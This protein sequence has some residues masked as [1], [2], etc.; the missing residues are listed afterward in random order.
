[1]T[2]EEILR[3]APEGCTHYLGDSCYIDEHY[4]DK[5]PRYDSPFET[6]EKIL[7]M[8]SLADIARIVELEKQNKWISVD[9]RLPEITLLDIRS[10]SVLVLRDCGNGTP[11]SSCVTF[12]W[13]ESQIMSQFHN[14]MYEKAERWDGQE[15]KGYRVT[16]WM[17]LP[18]F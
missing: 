17:P 5:L 4:K 7:P 6:K 1:M 10:D 8:R 9:D 12:M 11:Q 13:S 2:E 14:N 18:K 3:N 15:S 16:H